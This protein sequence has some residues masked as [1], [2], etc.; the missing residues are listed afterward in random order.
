MEDFNV[1]EV[2]YTNMAS[3]EESYPNGKTNSTC[4]DGSSRQRKIKKTFI[5]KKR[6][7]VIIHETRVL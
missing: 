5:L 2:V 1:L 3:S 4:R 7:S 6:N